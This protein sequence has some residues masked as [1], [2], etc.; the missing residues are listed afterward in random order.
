MPN[1][2]NEPLQ[3][4]HF[5][6]YLSSAWFFRYVSLLVII[7]VPFIISY[8]IEP[9]WL[10]ESVYVEQPKV[11]FKHQ[12]IVMLEG[13]TA[14]SEL[15]WS[16]YDQLNTMMGSKYRV[17]EV[18]ARQDDV[19]RDGKNDNIYLYLRVPLKS[20]E[21]IHHARFIMF[22]DYSLNDRVKLEMQTAAYFD[23][24]SVVPGGEC[25]VYGK[26]QLS[27]NQVLESNVA[28]RTLYNT[29]IIEP[30]VGGI[31]SIEQVLFTTM[32]SNYHARNET[33]EFAQ[34]NPVWVAGTGSEFILK[35]YIKI[36]VDQQILYKPGILENLRYG[37]LQYWA[38]YVVFAA[39]MN[40]AVRFIFTQQV[41]ETRVRDDS[42]PK[43]H[44]H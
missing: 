10:H 34:Q 36:P 22:F 7:F 37:I 5:A 44:V 28:V 35:A 29:P 6:P 30:T 15:I 23:H 20:G 43:G 16:T 27:Q 25:T 12:M 32:L 3:Q 13:N 42:Q 31:D 39:V 18:Q 38:I 9:F 17:A 26:L 11:D 19:N 21:A 41:F 24:V 40:Y 4:R 8:A 2:Y 14:G 33:T 1:V